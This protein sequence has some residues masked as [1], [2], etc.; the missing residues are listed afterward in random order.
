[1][2]PPAGRRGPRLALRLSHPVQVNAHIPPPAS[3]GLAVHHDEHDVL[4]LQVYGRKRW[5]VHDPDETSGYRLI[6]AELAP[7]DSLYI[8]QRFPPPPRPAAPASVHLTGG[9][10]PTTWMD[11]LRREVFSVVEEALSD[12]PLPAGY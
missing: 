1:F 11:V 3:Q 2:W 10:V 5:D 6:M 8:P 7:G 12:E 4:V 9:V